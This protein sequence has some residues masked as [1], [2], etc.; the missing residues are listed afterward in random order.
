MGD[1]IHTATVHF[2]GHLVSNVLPVVTINH[3]DDLGP[4]LYIPVCLTHHGRSNTGQIMFPD[5]F[6]QAIGDN[7][8]HNKKWTVQASCL[9]PPGISG[10]GLM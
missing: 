10:T 7:L 3:Q 8:S 1:V 4:Q 5:F 9:W 2:P 6:F